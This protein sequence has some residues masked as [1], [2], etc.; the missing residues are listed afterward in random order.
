MIKMKTLL[1]IQLIAEALPLSVARDFV[2]IQRNPKIKAQMNVIMD[3]L[4]KQPTAIVS[5]NGHRVAIPLQVKY[6]ESG[7]Y[8]S[9]ELKD[10]DMKLRSLIY[11][12]NEQGATKFPDLPYD[13]NQI[14]LGK[15]VDQY[16][17]EMKPAKYIQAL[18][19]TFYKNEPINTI[20]TDPWDRNTLNRFYQNIIT[21]RKKYDVIPDISSRINHM[22]QD[23][24]TE[25]DSIVEVQDFRSNKPRNYNMIFST[26]AYD[27]AGMSTGR[28][29]GS[30][31][32]LYMNGGATG[33]RFIQADIE[34]GTIISYLVSTTDLNIEKPSSRILIKPYINTE[35]PDDV[36]Y[37][38][39]PEYGTAPQL[40]F[41]TVLSLVDKAQPGKSGKFN[42][43]G[44]LYCD[45][46]RG[47]G[48]DNSSERNR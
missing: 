47:D 2:S 26:H 15:F 23:L 35:N 32:N 44:E 29:F 43:V 18:V 13:I 4:K 14:V 17:R 3:F 9:I 42:L 24:L 46:D 31:M 5:K 19:S 34:H 21:L 20:T 8:N 41:K 25:Y 6:G 10:F 22:V 11:R 27:I 7:T 38:A 12:V 16:G 45:S 28:G 48:N 1:E 40:Y 39:D 30:C 36:L 33:K 37:D